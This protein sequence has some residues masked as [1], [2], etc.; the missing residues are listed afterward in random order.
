M[1]FRRI[2]LASRAVVLVSLIVM[3]VLGCAAGTGTGPAGCAQASA[4]LIENINSGM[5]DPA[6]EIT[7][8]YVFPASNLEGPPVVTLFEDPVWVAAKAPGLNQPALWLAEGSGPGF[9]YVA[10]DAAR[11][12]NFAGVDLG[13]PPLAGDGEEAALAC[14]AS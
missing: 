1:G 14:A 4:A 11:A 6:N 8:A 2:V 5:N 3:I 13:G 10:N 12:I 7:A 9:A